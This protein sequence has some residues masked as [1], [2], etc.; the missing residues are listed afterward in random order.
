MKH[1]NGIDNCQNNGQNEIE[2]QVATTIQ[3]TKEEDRA[4]TQLKKKL[5][6]PSKK[7]VLLEGMQALTQIVEN[8]QRRTRLQ[9]ASLAVRRESIKIN[10]EWAPRST[11]L[12]TR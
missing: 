9:A 11:A 4:I 3:V 5:G 7:A 1:S 8:R 12:K 2:M 6:L 10:K